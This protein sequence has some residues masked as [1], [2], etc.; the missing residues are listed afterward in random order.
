MF[1]ILLVA[2][3]G[4]SANPM[5]SIMV[6]SVRASPP[7]IYLSSFWAFDLSG[8]II[9]TL[10][11]SATVDSGV[12]GGEFSPVVLDSSNTSG[13]TINHEAEYLFIDDPVWAWVHWGWLGFNS[14]PLQNSVTKFINN[15]YWGYCYCF[16]FVNYLSWGGTNIIINEIASNNNWTNNSNF[17]E[18]Y[19][20]ADTA[21]NL[22]SWLIACDTIY[23]IP[24]GTIIQPDDF[25]V[26]DQIEF[27]VSFDLDYD[28]DN[29]YLIN[30]NLY[31]VDQVGWSSDH[32]ENVSFVRYPDGDVD[33]SNYCLGFQGYN[34]STSYTFEN[35]FPS[36]GASNRHDSPGFVVIGVHALALDIGIDLDW[37]SP[38]WDPTFDEVR[39]VRNVEHYPETVDDGNTVYEG[40]A[41][42]F[43]DI[44]APLNNPIH[45][46]IFAKDINGQYST[47]T[48]ESRVLV[49]NGVVGIENELI[50]EKI[51]FLKAYPNPFNNKTIINFN[52]TESSFVT[53]SIYNMLGQQ[54]DILVNESLSSG[55]HEATWDANSFSSGIYL[56]KLETAGQVMS[57]K[58]QLL[59]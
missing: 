11:D 45:Y 27:P 8:T 46:T 1:L 42:K 23:E 22:S 59:K 48:E 25:Y 15:S 32:G 43:L 24:S 58:I 7:E 53:L 44:G 36:R 4:A 35:G 50:P 13:F 47:P 3:I 10:G 52:L 6:D 57:I 20:K 30:A 19:N 39:I 29:I 33:S 40:D 54:L 56:A 55:E 51:S 38:V 5:P 18:L 49:I 16:D 12:V 41:Q 26:L 28:S 21:I 14:P 37:T 17:I 9:T 34:D 2:F 31:I